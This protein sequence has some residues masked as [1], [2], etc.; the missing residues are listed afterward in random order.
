MAGDP[1]FTT[2]A[3]LLAWIRQRLRYPDPAPDARLRALQH[4]RR[5]TMAHA[6]L[7]GDEE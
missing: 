2:R 7:L 6:H 3:E 4:I 5:V 1:T